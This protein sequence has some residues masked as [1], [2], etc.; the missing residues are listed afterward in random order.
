MWK[1]PE[2]GKYKQMEMFNGDDDM[3]QKSLEIFS[4]CFTFDGWMWSFWGALTLEF[5]A[6][7]M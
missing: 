6:Q 1:K 3:T 2:Y 4:I 7:S 5:I